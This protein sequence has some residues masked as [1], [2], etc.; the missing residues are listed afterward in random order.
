MD[1]QTSDVPLAKDASERFLPWLIAFMVYLAGLALSSAMVTRQLVER[2]DTGLSGQITVEVPLANLE[3]S[4]QERAADVA[5]V[6]EVLTG[7]PGVATATQ[8]R[9][10]EIA[11]L[12]EPWLGSSLADQDLPLP[13]MIAVTMDTAKPPDLTALREALERAVPGTLLDDHQRWLRNLL[14]LARSMQLVAAVIV[15]LVGAAAI[16]S[17]AFVARAGLAMHGQA[18]QLLH[19]IGA[20]DAY[21]ARQFQR[22]ALRLGLRG[23]IIGTLL[24]LA[25]IVPIGILIER[26]QSGL[27][28]DLSWSPLEWGLLASLPVVTALVTMATARFTVLG[29]LARMP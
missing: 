15:A 11:A 14:D 27:L 8:Y 25:T 20:R 9:S 22:H 5:K 23:G 10:D 3:A 26:S 17:V 7:T 18:I 29:T 6:L 12:L 28:P 24:A 21:I 4:Q 19:L 16:L 13:A 1:R 2:W